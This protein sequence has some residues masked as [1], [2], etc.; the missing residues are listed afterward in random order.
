MLALA[1]LVAIG[2]AVA[3]GSAKP[4]QLAEFIALPGWNIGCLYMPRRGLDVPWLRCEVKS[5]LRIALPQ[6]MCETTIGVMMYWRSRP[7]LECEGAW[8]IIAAGPSTT[9]LKPGTTWRREG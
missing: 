6:P 5:G 1:S 3:P 7:G 8:L 2:T 9:V 4:F